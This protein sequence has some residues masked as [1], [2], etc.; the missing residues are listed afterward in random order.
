MS[1][2]AMKGK[3]GIFKGQYQARRTT[4]REIALITLKLSLHRLYMFSARTEK[5]PVTPTIVNG[6]IENLGLSV[7]SNVF[8]RARRIWK[9]FNIV[10]HTEKI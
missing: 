7:L 6:W 10:Q 4:Q 8:G 1:D 9:L 2:Q 3:N 5:G